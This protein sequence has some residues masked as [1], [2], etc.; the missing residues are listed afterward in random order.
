[1]YAVLCISLLTLHLRHPRLTNLY[2]PEVLVDLTW[3]SPHKAISKAIKPKHASALCHGAACPIHLCCWNQYLLRGHGPNRPRFFQL[4]VYAHAVAAAAASSRLL[5][6]T[7]AETNEA[8]TG[9]QGKE[10]R[11][12][13]RRISAHGEIGLQGDAYTESESGSLFYAKPLFRVC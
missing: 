5:R 9:D 13:L 12:Q 10:E 4:K 11:A 1:M 7:A 3:Y 8:S 6:S 2:V